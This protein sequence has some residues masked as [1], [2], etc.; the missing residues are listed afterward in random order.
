MSAP[1]NT[2]AGPPAGSSLLLIISVIGA[3][4]AILGAGLTHDPIFRL[5][6]GTLALAG[7][8]AAFVL[9]GGLAGGTLRDHPDQYSDNVV[10]AGVIATMF[11]AAAGLLVGVLI[12]A[13]LSWPRI[14]YFP[15]LGFL[16]FGRLR[17]LHTSAV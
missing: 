14:F 4:L 17:P 16:N 3:F 1:S 11:W 9:N 10:K 15:E 6:A 2:S 12:A 13:Q 7:V 5:Q 8:I